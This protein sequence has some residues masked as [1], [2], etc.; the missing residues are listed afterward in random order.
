MI[1][2]KKIEKAVRNYI[3]TKGYFIK[4]DEEPCVDIEFAYKDGA[5]WAINEFLKDSWHSIEEK[6]EKEKTFL[7][8]TSFGGFGLN[9]VSD[10]KDWDFIIKYQKATKWI[11]IEDLPPKQKGE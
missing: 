8:Q 2:D 3:N 10:K 11:Y 5:K 7:Y 1:D 6:P 4:Y 9:Q